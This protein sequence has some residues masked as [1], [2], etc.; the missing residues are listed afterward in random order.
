M[1]IY[2]FA[3]ISRNRVPTS[4]LLTM[5][6]GPPS[7]DQKVLTTQ[8]VSVPEDHQSKVQLNSPLALQ[9]ITIKKPTV[10]KSKHANHSGRTK[11]AEHAKHVYNISF[12]SSLS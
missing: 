10:N 4:N 2:H 5:C 12:A 6:H 1:C 11:Q 3:G 9:R 7:S 8:E